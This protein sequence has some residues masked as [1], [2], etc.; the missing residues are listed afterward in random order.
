M[1]KTQYSKL[2]IAIYVFYM[3]LALAWFVTSLAVG[4][5]IN[6]FALVTL[7]AFAFPD[8]A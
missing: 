1:N 7:A 5:Y 3:L 8:T 2:I 4:G 6:Y